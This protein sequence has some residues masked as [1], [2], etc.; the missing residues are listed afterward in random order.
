MHSETSESGQLPLRRPSTIHRVGSELVRVTLYP[1]LQ[2]RWH[3]SASRYLRQLRKYEFA[4]LESIQA[5][6]LNRLRALLQ[7]AGRHVPYYRNLF[8]AR[9]FDPSEVRSLADLGRLPVLTKADIRQN[10]AALLAENYNQGRMLLN[11]SGGSTGK[12]LQFY[13]DSTYWDYACASQWFVESWWGIRRGDRTA[14]IWGTDRDIPALSWREKVCQTKACNAFALTEERMERFARELQS[15]YPRFVVGY[16]SALHLFARFLIERPYLR[17]RPHA[18]KSAAEVLTDNERAVIE[19]AFQCPVY[20]FYGSREVNN[21]AAE[22][23]AHTGLHVNALTRFIELVDEAGA[24]TEPGAAGR[25][26]VTDLVNYGMPFI[27]YEIEDLGRWSATP[28][29]CGRPFPL[30]G[31]VLGRKSDFI[32]TSAGK[33]IHGEFFT[34]MFYGMPAVTAF[35]LIQES[36]TEICLHVVLQPGAEASLLEPLR[37]RLKIAL[38]ESVHCRIDAVNEIERLP[39]GKHRFTVS[40]VTATLQSAQTHASLN[41]GAELRDNG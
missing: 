13:Q 38:G 31:K 10:S 22:C 9:A 35:Q 40:N 20:D 8:R 17:I 28:C 24:P 4:S 11:A 37:D 12:P 25:I 26:L 27:R 14:S 6:Q 16:A 30:L 18:V 34:H 39:S 23:P 3:P 32:V 15:W 19:R 21:L 2:R 33:F 29:S 36:L 41:P 1:L 7:H 5:A